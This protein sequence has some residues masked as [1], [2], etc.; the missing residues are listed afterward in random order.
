MERERER[1]RAKERAVG[2]RERERE[3]ERESGSER[4]TSFD[5]AERGVASKHEPRLTLRIAYRR[6][7]QCGN[8]SP[9]W[10]SC[11]ARCAPPPNPPPRMH[12][13]CL[14]ARARSLCMSL[15]PCAQYVH[16]SCTVP[17][18]PRVLRR[19][20]K[21]SATTC[22]PFPCA[23]AAGGARA[24]CRHTSGGCPLRICSMLHVLLDARRVGRRASAN[25]QR[26]APTARDPRAS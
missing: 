8:W 15:A 24:A 11:R 1:E 25:V 17:T 23:F 21:G 5:V 13:Q 26:C 16:V 14:Y 12:G 4:A 9:V 2:E 10:L 20:G 3:S 18:L 7:V 22:D 6:R 19:A